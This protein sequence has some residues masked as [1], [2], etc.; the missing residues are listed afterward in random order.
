MGTTAALRGRI[1]PETAEVRR[2]IAVTH[3]ITTLSI[4]GAEMMLYRLLCAM[5]RSSFRNSVISL[6]Q[7]DA[8][9]EKIRAAGVPVRTL[10]LRPAQVLSGVVRLGRE[11]R[12]E[13]PDVIQTWMYH[14]DLFGGLASLAVR[15]APVAWN[16]RCG[17]LEPSI[18]KR[19]TIWI[20]RLCA[21]LSRVLPTRIVSCSEAGC[22]VHASA[23]YARAKMRTIPNGFDL[24]QYRPD[25]MSRMAMRKE[26][27]IDEQ[28][29]LIG[30]V[31]RFNRAKDHATLLGALSPIL[32][33]SRFQ[34]AIC[35]EGITDANSELIALLRAAGIRNGC[36]LLGRGEDI[37]R[38]L[39]AL[40]V[41]VSSSAV[42]GFPNAIGE[43]M[44]CGVPCV[45]TA[46]GDSRRLVGETGLVVPVRNPD[47]LA[48]AVCQL[49]ELGPEGRTALGL[50]ARRRVRDLFGIASV[51]RQYEELYREMAAACAA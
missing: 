6:G 34:L 22:D 12:R 37:P 10:G 26:L 44:A 4:G 43:A 27:G 24:E 11:L 2:P 23:G 19:S 40:D 32:R 17:G 41:F 30:S 51:A 35:G 5:D 29:L 25:R 38:F 31:G 3:V 47:A 18:D 20:S 16:I 36:H 46:A 50:Q 45:V 1:L 21:G 48:S 7:E 28:T 42:E 39:A 13:K 49:I 14:A 8:I 33:D 15:A 9:A